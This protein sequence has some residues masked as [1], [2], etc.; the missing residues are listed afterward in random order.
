MK[1]SVKPQRWWLLFLVGGVIP[2]TL[3][4]GSQFDIP[5]RFTIPI[6]V[7]AALAFG[8]MWIWMHANANATGD[9]WWQD[10]SS[11]GWRGY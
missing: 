2:L 6:L 5:Q 11:S 3:I 1:Q 4:L 8:A 7:I 9:E 10:N